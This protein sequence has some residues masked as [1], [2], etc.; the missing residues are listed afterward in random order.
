MINILAL[1]DLHGKIPKIHIKEN[2][3]D[4]IIL[5]GDICCD[6]IRIY[7][8]KLRVAKK[9]YE[10]KYQKLFYKS[11]EKPIYLKKLNSLKVPKITE[12]ISKND[13]KK[14]NIRSIKRG[15]EILKF[16]NKFGKPIFLVPGNWD[17]TPNDGMITNEGKVWDNMIKKYKNVF[18]VENKKKIFENIF[19]LG[20]GSTSNVEPLKKIPKNHNLDI[21]EIERIEYNSRCDY[22][23]KINNNL[24]KIFSSNKNKKP[25]IFISHNSPYNTKLDLVN[26]KKIKI[27]NKHFG[28]IISKNLI[29]KFQPTLCLS[30]HIHEGFGKIKIGKTICINLGYGNDI[31]TL[32]KFDVKKNKILKIKFFG[33]SKI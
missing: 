33:K 12:F 10:K 31:N 6:G 9:K 8:N 3:F 27:K 4:I 32:I 1:G 30:G 2:E 18:D 25:T 15:E 29:K 7:M 20:H 22:F 21:D 11:F 26:N 28:S 19:F 24:E 23:K 13:L 14:M 5:P 17:P 16:L